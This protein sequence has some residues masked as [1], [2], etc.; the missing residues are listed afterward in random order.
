M[1]GLIITSK[2]SDVDL[3]VHV[4]MCTY[5]FREGSLHITCT[6]STTNRTESVTVEAES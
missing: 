4:Y 3:D 6:E 2:K 1:H 5:T